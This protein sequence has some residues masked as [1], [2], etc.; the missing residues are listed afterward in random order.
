MT[1]RADRISQ[2]K[3]QPIALAAIKEIKHELK[4]HQHRLDPDTYQRFMEWLDDPERPR[5]QKRGR[6]LT[7][8]L[9]ETY[10]AVYND[11]KYIGELYQ[12]AHR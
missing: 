12:E 11:G 8:N 5:D 7:I 9:P 2:E 1:L 4:N 6:Y 10:T 3:Y